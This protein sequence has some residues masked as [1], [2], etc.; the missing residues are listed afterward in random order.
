MSILKVGVIGLGR[1]GKVHLENLVQRIPS[2]KVIA[3]SNPSEAAHDFARQLGITKIYKEGKEVVFHK[4]VEGVIICS[5]TDTHAAYV[6][7]AAKAGKHIFCEKPLEMSP[8]AIEELIAITKEQR[9]KLQVGFNRR[10]DANFSKVQQQVEN[11]NIGEPHILKITSRDPSP[12]PLDYI[13]VSGGM[14]LDMSIHDFDMARF[15]VGSEV[16]EVFAQTAVRVNPDIGEAGDIDTAII[17]LKFKNGCLGVID[18]S[19]EAV[20]GY[21]QRVEIFGSKGMSRVDNKYADN[22][23]L[24][25]KEGVSTGLPLHFFMERYTDSFCQEMKAFITAIRENKRVPVNGQDALMATKIAVA[26]K[27]SARLNRPVRLD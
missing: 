14:F 5:P 23:V 8:N 18:N 17:T 16:E 24:Y 22:Q 7:M 12:P 1:I 4:E 6:K 10:F 9:V 13:K 21:D 15:I 19:R 2:V 20:Y 11:G 26:A 25:G 27:E 3:V